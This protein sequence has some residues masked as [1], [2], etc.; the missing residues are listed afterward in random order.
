MFYVQ[1]GLNT[2]MAYDYKSCMGLK[3]KPRQGDGL[4]FYSLF[5]NGTIDKVEFHLSLKTFFCARIWSS[6]TIELLF[7]GHIE[8]ENIKSMYIR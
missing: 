7:L 4:L 1:N 2:R 5:P 6:D 8:I 3:I